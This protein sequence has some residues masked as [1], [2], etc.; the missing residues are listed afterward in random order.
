MRIRVLA[1][2]AILA[3][4]CGTAVYAQLPER[5]AFRPATFGHSTYYGYNNTSMGDSGKITYA[6][7]HYA[8]HGY[9]GGYSGQ[10]VSRAYRLEP[11]KIVGYSPYSYGVKANRHVRSGRHY[12]P[13]VMDDCLCGS[14][15]LIESPHLAPTPQKTPQPAKVETDVLPEPAKQPTIVKPETPVVKDPPIVAPP[16]PIVE[17]KPEV[18]EPPKTSVD[19]PA[20]PD[21]KDPFGPAVS[22]AVEGPKVDVPSVD[23]TPFPAFDDEGT[24]DVEDDPFGESAPALIDTEDLAE[25]DE[26]PF[27]VGAPALSDFGAEDDDEGDGDD[28]FGESTPA[29]L[30]P[31]A[32]QKKES[33][34]SFDPTPALD[35]DDSDPFGADLT[36]EPAPADTDTD[37]FADESETEDADSEDDDFNPFG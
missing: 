2:L 9:R 19:P 30:V 20:V 24:E 13:I 37:P 22:P 1:V 31:D 6:S 10:A 3:G 26:D 23:T 21:E 15:G 12:T 29:P 34:P 36:D 32:T 7:S 18:V 28:P 27:G 25:N 16:A 14:G 11:S 5:V 4:F 8:Q 33:I 17:T 35:D